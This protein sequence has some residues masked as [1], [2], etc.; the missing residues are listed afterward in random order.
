[1]KKMGFIDNITTPADWKRDAISRATVERPKL[2]RW[3]T[4]GVA[5]AAVAIMISL[6]LMPVLFV[7]NPPVMHEND[8]ESKG[9]SQE[10]KSEVLTWEGEELTEEEKRQQAIIESMKEEYDE[11]YVVSVI[12]FEETNEPFLNDLVIDE[13]GTK[14]YM[15][16]DDLDPDLV[17]TGANQVLITGVDDMNSRNELFS[18]VIRSDSTDL[19]EGGPHKPQLGDKIVVG[20]K[21]TY[22][23]NSV[24]NHPKYKL[25]KTTTAYAYLGEADNLKFTNALSTARVAARGEEDETVRLMG[26]HFSNMSRIAPASISLEL[27]HDVDDRISASREDWNTGMG[28]DYRITFGNVGSGNYDMK[29]YPLI[30]D[31]RYYLTEGITSHLFVLGISDRSGNAIDCH[32]EEGKEGRVL[33]LNGAKG[34]FYIDGTTEVELLN[35][36]IIHEEGEST[37]YILLNLTDT[38]HTGNIRG[39]VNFHID[40]SDEQADT[41]APMTEV[42]DAMSK[43]TVI[44]DG[45]LDFDIVPHDVVNVRDTKHIDGNRHT[46]VIYSFDI[47]PGYYPLDPVCILSNISNL[48]SDEIMLILSEG[49]SHEDRLA[50]A[51]SGEEIPYLPRLVIKCNE[52]HDI[53]STKHSLHTNDDGTVTLS[54]IVSLEDEK[55][56]ND[57]KISFSFYEEGN[58]EAKITVV[59][60]EE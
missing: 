41:G 21:Y 19:T 59:F 10:D 17:N 22:L 47:K 5:A 26:S 16:V 9:S 60:E 3:Q 25:A 36:E 44:D 11:V 57:K 23:N 33:N 51:L 30:Y 48:T 46:D 50:L 35:T 53:E 27:T 52:G 1:M 29:L 38:E 28:T 14:I 54:I 8:D 12:S 39:E 15:A 20:G 31:D 58:E 40:F 2:K 6:V 7:R 34:L 49:L 42:R 13:Y 45:S 55:E 32:W 37:A 24:P 43:I 56:G 18:L 4:A